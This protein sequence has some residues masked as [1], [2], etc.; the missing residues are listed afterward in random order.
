MKEDRGFS[1]VELLVVVAIMG[2]MS[3][4]LFIGLSLMTG[5]N[6]KECA[7][8]MSAALGKEKNYALTKSATIDCY[9]ELL[10]ESGAYYVKYYIPKNAVVEGHDA[11]DW[12]LAEEQKVGSGI[13]D[14][15]CTFEDG[16]TVT[17]T[18]GQSVKLIYN[19]TDG[20]FKNAVT[21]NGSTVGTEGGGSTHCTDITFESG[22]KY[23]II[24][25][26]A[27]GKHVLSRVN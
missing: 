19:R 23:E 9:L 5:Q 17:I 21:S 11:S 1:L 7:N 14:V 6:A 10:H 22:K 13:L 25:Y 16:T 2:V 26:P 18:D 20:A 27:T 3:G 24:L 12:V 4:F 8:N 15:E